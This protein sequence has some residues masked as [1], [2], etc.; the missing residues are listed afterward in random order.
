MI[1][2]N[3]KKSLNLHV[4]GHP[5]FISS[6]FILILNDWYLKETFHN[7]ITGK[8]SDFAGL[9]TFPIFLSVLFPRYKL[10]A[11]IFAGLVFMYW[12]SAISQPLIDRL[13]LIGLHVDRT[14]D[15]TDS[16]AL[17]SI[18]YAYFA[19]NDQRYIRMWPILQ[20]AILI[21][22]ATAFV[23]T[24]MPPHSTRKYTEIGKEYSFG[25]S[26]RELISRLNMVQIK[27][28]RKLN[29]LSGQVD[30]DADKNIFHYKGQTDTLALLLD[31]A[32]VKKTDTITFRTSL[33]ENMISG[34]E[35]QSRLRLISVYRVV[36]DH[37]EKDY[38]EKAVRS[39]EKHIIRPIRKYGSSIR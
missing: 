26:K 19:S 8:L 14:V 6:T 11:H 32:L 7:E 13:Q 2:P 10:T 35:Q 4:L 36:P 15:I 12:N 28:V 38:R 30:F 33:A 9:F 20:K 17:I 23:A 39:F 16:I 29:R 18:P 22:S 25:F 37:K 24:T 3:H 21:L 5:L 34:D 27:E 31:E 1:P